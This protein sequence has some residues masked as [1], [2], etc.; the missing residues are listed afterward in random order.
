[1]EEAG[2]NPAL[3]YGQAGPGGSTMAVGAGNASGSQASDEMAQ[4]QAATQL[5]GMG[6]QGAMIASQI[7][8]NQAQAEKLKAEAKK[9]LGVDTELAKRQIDNITEDIANK[10]VQRTGMILQNN[11]DEIRNEIR[12]AT[13][14]SE[15]RSMDF[16]AKQTA[17]NLEK[18]NREI[19]SMDIDIEIKNKTK[20]A[21]IE[22]AELQ[23]EQ[24]MAD[25]L[26]KES[27]GRLNDTSAKTLVQQI[28]INLSQL[29]TNIDKNA[30]EREMNEILRENN[31]TTAGTNA[32]S[33]LT[34]IIVG[35][36]MLRAAGGRPKTIKGFK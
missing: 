20:E 35:T 10:S 7:Q 4:K 30:I 13:A 19:E 23:N 22:S 8:V 6:L 27:Q 2:L 5:Q 9:S 3:M 15:I 28:G 16:L 29:G 34:N 12:E 31:I 26:V 33:S 21:I 1:M 25:I 14:G 17:K 11:Y 32:I 24:I 36:L 18:L